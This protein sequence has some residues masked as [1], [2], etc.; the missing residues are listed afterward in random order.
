MRPTEAFARRRANRASA[1]SLAA[2]SPS[3]DA[4]VP[5]RSYNLLNSGTGATQWANRQGQ[6]TTLETM[7]GTATRRTRRRKMRRA[8][9]RAARC[10]R[11]A[12]WPPRRSRVRAPAASATRA[13]HRHRHR[14]GHAVPRVRPPRHHVVDRRA[15]AFASS[16]RG[17]C[18]C[19]RRPRAAATRS[20]AACSVTER[21]RQ[22][23]HPE[24]LG[25]R[26]RRGRRRGGASRARRRPRAR[27]RHARMRPVL[28]M[29]AR[30]SRGV[31]L[32]EQPALQRTDRGHG[33]RH[34][35]AAAGRDRRLERDHGRARGVLHSGIHR[36]AGRSAR[37][38]RRHARGRPSLDD[39]VCARGGRLE[40]R[41]LRGGAHRARR[42]ARRAKP[43]GWAD[44]RRRADRI[45]PARRRS[46]SA[47][48]RSS[49]RTSTP[50]R[51]S[52]ASARSATGPTDRFDAG[53]R[54]G[55]GYRYGGADF[56]IEGS[57]GDLFPPAVE[58][59]PR[60]DGPARDP[61]GVGGHDRRRALDAAR[62]PG[63]RATSRSRRRGF[64]SR[65]ARSTAARWAACTRCATRRATSR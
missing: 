1:P 16:G 28:S 26:R 30:P 61:P 36:P 56:V 52:S 4:A 27:Q 38:A 40:R 20:R 17:R 41:D 15:C 10:S 51:S 35:R 48:R 25:L 60:S 62:R 55:P 53:G 18:S 33:R 50:I 13:R 49:T 32:P 29:P 59:G 45:S 34:R 65:R 2:P 44:H 63:S 7:R 14:R 8:A 22:S 31:Q 64:A 21:G 5:A 23:A 43:L 37:A 9:Y 12:R 54:Y 19:A 11:P 3:A 58:E 47:R 42:R 57:G 6:V 46:I 39:D 24:S